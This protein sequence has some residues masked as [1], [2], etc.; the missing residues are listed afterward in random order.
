MNETISIAGIPVSLVPIGRNE[1]RGLNLDL[2]LSFRFYKTEFN[3]YKLCIAEPADSARSYTPRQYN[4]TATQIERLLKI[5]VAFRL[6]AAPSYMRSRLIEQG[7]YFIIS[8]QYVF[9]PG[10]LI[11]E[12]MKRTGN[13]TQRLSPP[14]QYILLY[15]L[16]HKEIEEFTIRDIQPR[17]PYNYLAVSRAVNELEEKQLFKAQREWKTKLISSS[18]PRKELWENAIS[19][20]S[21]PVKKTIYTDETWRG[22]FYLGGISALSHYSFL[23]PDDQ[24]TFVIWEKEFDPENHSYMEWGDP[25]FRYKIEIWKY[26][27]EMDIG[28]D[29]YVDKLSLYLSMPDENDPRVEKELETIINEI[30]Q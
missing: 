11:N 1:L 7:V 25:D 4:R 6:P 22:P 10:L 9:L 24:Q 13:P 30:W 14:A 15:Y 27:P 12:R 28:Q 16:L 17:T 8:D 26:S 19:Y 2:Q 29:E 21:S 5:P 20:L 23:N 3:R 18:V